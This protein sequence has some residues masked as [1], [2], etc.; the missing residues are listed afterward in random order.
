MFRLKDTTRPRKD[1]E[2]NG[3]DYYFYE[4]REQMECDIQ[5]HLFIEAG[6]YKGNLYGTSVQSVRA[7]ANKGRH[8]ILEVSPKAIKRLK[9]AQLYPIVLFIKAPNIEWIM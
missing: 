5:N 4:T 7:V 9:M 3:R 8:C 1:F 6:Q 2:V